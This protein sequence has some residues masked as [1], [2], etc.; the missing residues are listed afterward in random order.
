M[1]A[2]LEPGARSRSTTVNEKAEDCLT[3]LYVG[4]EDI[5]FYNVAPD[6]LR[7]EVMVHNRGYSLSGPVAIQLQ[8]AAFGAFVPWTPLQKLKVPQIKA[9]QSKLVSTDARIRP[10]GTLV[11]LDG[12]SKSV[13]PA[14]LAAAQRPTFPSNLM[15]L[16]SDDGI[17]STQNAINL[18]AS[19]FLGANQG[20][21]VQSLD[22]NLH[23]GRSVHWVGN[24]NVLIGNVD[25]ERHAARAF[26]IYPGL[27][28][29]SVFF[30]GDK[31]GESY[32][33]QMSDEGT[34]WP[35]KLIRIENRCWG[36]MNFAQGEDSQGEQIQP[37]DWKRVDPIGLIG[38]DIRPPEYVKEGGLGIEVCRKS[39]GRTA[40]V[41][42]DFSET[43]LGSGCYT[44]QGS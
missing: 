26:R 40:V 11:A 43:A 22:M 19:L 36:F 30:L 37:N 23:R 44:V 27:S 3:N 10:D 2:V 38:V 15:G 5:Q 14:F 20:N 42:F 6:R 39:D 29:R 28:N 17:Q 25:V 34:E 1:S 16:P 21:Q 33:F 4:R 9:G 31:I 8:F 13:D 35:T 7:I 32:S 18:P 41:E 12:S 24:I